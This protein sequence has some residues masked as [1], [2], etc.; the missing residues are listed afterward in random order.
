M[1][2]RLLLTM[3]AAAGIVTGLYASGHLPPEAHRLVSDLKNRLMTPGEAGAAPIV[4]RKAADPRLKEVPPPAITVARAATER[5]TVS[6]LVTGTLVPREEIL[7]APEVE[8]LR[9]LEVVAEE[10]MRVSKGDVLARIETQTLI[11]QLAQNAAQVARSEA[12]IA[13]A[14]SNI[15]AAEARLEEASAAF[16]RAK[17]LRKSG[18]LSESTFDQREAAQKTA[19]SQLQAARDG[20]KLAEA[21]RNQAAAQRREIEWRLSKTEIRAP[22]DGIISRRNARIGAMATAAGE[23]MFRIIAAGAVELD[24]EVPEMQ[25]ARLKAGQPARVLVAGLGEIDGTVRI[26]SPEVDRASR[27]GKVRILLADLTAPRIGSFA[28]GSVVTAEGRGIAVPASAIQYSD[29]GPSVQVVRGDTIQSAKVTLGLSTSERVEVTSGV[30]EGDLV[31][32]KAGTFLRHG[33]RVRPV[34]AKAS[35]LSGV[36]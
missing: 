24:A 33:D 1:M 29:S 2:R 16:E 22:A 14:R 23:P 5:F 10:G 30:A 27:L 18:V 15:A 17:P 13:Q 3:L 26:V 11:T 8:G 19:D 12:Q 31:V 4:A 21:E 32:V 20:L 28:R 36:Q 6:I 34:P 25:L 7:V 9:L 35:E